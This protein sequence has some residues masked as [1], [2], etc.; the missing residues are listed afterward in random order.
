M[1]KT[2]FLLIVIEATTTNTEPCV[3]VEVYALIRFLT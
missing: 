3:G 2:V 1:I